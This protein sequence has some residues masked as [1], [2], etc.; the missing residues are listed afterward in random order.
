MKPERAVITIE[1]SF[2]YSAG[3][4]YGWCGEKGQHDYDQRGVGI[5][6]EYLQNYPEIEVIVDGEAYLLDCDKAIKFIRNFNSLEEYKGVRVGIVSKSLL[7]SMRPF[8][9][10]TPKDEQV[11][12]SYPQESLQG[13]LF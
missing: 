5:K 13:K 9:V 4:K 2:Y 6:V 7:I 12:T 8:P 3:K 1:K 11:N 10:T